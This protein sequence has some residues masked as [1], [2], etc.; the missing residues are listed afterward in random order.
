VVVDL[1]VKEV[2]FEREVIEVQKR[3]KLDFRLEEF[4]EEGRKKLLLKRSWLV[5]VEE[6]QVKRVRKVQ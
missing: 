6:W 1:V 3:M 4:G 5:E 2:G